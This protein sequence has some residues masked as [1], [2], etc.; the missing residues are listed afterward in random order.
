MLFLTDPSWENGFY[1][2]HTLW[3]RCDLCGESGT[4][5]RKGRRYCH[6][7]CDGNAVQAMDLVICRDERHRL[8][9]LDACLGVGILP[10]PLW[11][12]L[13]PVSAQST[14]TLLLAA[15][16]PCFS[17]AQRREILEILLDRKPWETS[18][19]AKR[20]ETLAICLWQWRKPKR[21]RK[22]KRKEA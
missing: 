3:G 18:S 8:S 16:A 20:A 17:E 6:K 22:N 21:N 10:P 5:I 2:P 4:L 14:E 7:G 12:A 9:L 19:V 1:H 15:A 13:E 11:E